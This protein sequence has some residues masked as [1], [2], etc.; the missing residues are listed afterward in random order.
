MIKKQIIA[1]VLFFLFYSFIFSQIPIRVNESLNNYSIGAN[2]IKNDTLYLHYLLSSKFVNTI[3]GNELFKEVKLIKSHSSIQ[4][5]GIQVLK[6][7]FPSFYSKIFEWSNEV[8]EFGCLMG[9][10]LHDSSTIWL[11]KFE[12]PFDSM[13]LFPLYDSSFGRVFIKANLILGNNLYLFGEVRYQSQTFSNP[14]A[15]KINL[16]TKKIQLQ[17]FTCNAPFRFFSDAIYDS[18][19]QNFIVTSPAQIENSNPPFGA[20]ICRIDTHLNLIP[21]S[22]QTLQ[23]NYSTHLITSPNPYEYVVGIEPINAHQ[24]LSVGPANNPL[25][26]PSQTPNTNPNYLEDLVAGQRSTS[27]LLETSTSYAHGKIDTAE[28]SSLDLNTFKKVDSNLYYVGMTSRFYNPQP[29][30]WDTELALFGLNEHG[31]KHWE[32]YEPLNDY[33]YISDII[34]D[35]KGGLWYVAQCS[36][37]LN[38]STGEYESFIKVGYVDSVAYWPRIGA[39]GIE[40][41]AK[42][43]EDIQIYP[44]PV[45]HEFTIKQ[46]GFVQSLQ[47]RIYNLQGALLQESQSQSHKSTIDVSQLKS[48]LYLIHVL[49]EKGQLIKEHKLVKP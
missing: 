13:Y 30:P 6:N 29:E 14:T 44:N 1:L 45:E 15:F 41:P 8:Y 25:Q 33:C 20:G 12:E 35:Q 26:L 27:T 32:Y 49:D 46:Y 34:P 5:T 22:N 36:E 9:P 23:S 19:N 11:K 18:I 38:T 24:F 4:S 28:S 7:S 17:T 43:A 21:G 48:G 10:N 42:K 47:F 40:T 39:V 3:D 2:Y 16:Q 37:N 31:Q